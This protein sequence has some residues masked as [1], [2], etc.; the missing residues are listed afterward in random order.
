M[1]GIK[2]LNWDGKNDLGQKLGNGLYFAR[3]E[4]ESGLET[5][6]LVLIK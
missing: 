2:H 5:V 6:K 1:P 3:P 4:N